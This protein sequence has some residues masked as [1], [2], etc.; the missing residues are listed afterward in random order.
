[1]SLDL[2]RLDVALRNN[3]ISGNVMDE[4]EL[5]EKLTAVSA[6]NV[7]KYANGAEAQA[8]LRRRVREDLADGEEVIESCGIDLADGYATELTHINNKSS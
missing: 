3:F 4:L 5:M 6:L 2:K 1:M 7:T 8:L